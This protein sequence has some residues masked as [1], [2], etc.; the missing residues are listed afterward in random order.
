LKL[1]TSSDPTAALV[2]VVSSDP[3]VQAE[4]KG[5]LERERWPTTTVADPS[6]AVARMAEGDVG[7]VL[8]DLALGS[9][10]IDLVA[11][12]RELS[13]EPTVVLLVNPSQRQTAARGMKLGAFAYV[14]KPI[15]PD[16]IAAHVARA[17]QWQ[18]GRHGE[19]RVAR[20]GPGRS[21]NPV[22]AGDE[23]GRLGAARLLCA[24]RHRDAETAGHLERIGRYAEVI[25]LA[26]DWVTPEE[27]ETLRL[28]AALHDLGKFAI[29]DSVLQKPGRLTPSEREAVQ[30]HTLL[31]AAIL[32]REAGDS[33]LIE[34]T[35][36]VCLHHHE[37]WDGGGYPDRLAGEAIPAWA[38][39]VTV[40]DVYDALVHDR[41]YRPAVPEN[42]ALGYMRF[43]RARLFDPRVYDAFIEHLPELRKIRWQVRETQAA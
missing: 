34:A 25:G 13:P 5:V 39:I 17:H 6:A 16:E 7:V 24:L 20:L 15:Y 4:V 29:P 26:L 32:G 11:T 36:Q 1:E 28:A 22:S 18:A 37:R 38:R 41:V 10:A 8:C 3:V 12:A 21:P 27:A 33:P 35:R 23:A 9:A 31:G 2:L 19:S 40:V 43:Q 14:T 30:R 42:V